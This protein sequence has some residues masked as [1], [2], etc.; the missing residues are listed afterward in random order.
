MGMIKRWSAK[1]TP[2]KV[3]KY[4]T[5]LEKTN[6]NL[7]SGYNCDWRDFANECRATN[8]LYGKAL[9][10]DERKYYHVVQSFSPYDNVTPEKAHEIALKFAEKHFKGFQ[11]L[12]ATHTDREHIHTHFIINAVS[13]ETGKKYHAD[14]KSLWS[15]RK[16]SNGYCQDYGFENSIQPLDRRAK[17]KVKSGELR[18]ILAGRESWKAEL[19]AQIET[20]KSS[21]QTAAEFK[22]MMKNEYGVEVIESTRTRRDK[23]TNI[24]QYKMPWRELPCGENRLGLDFGKESIERG[25]AERS[26]EKA[27]R[28]SSENARTAERNDSR[29]D[30]YEYRDRSVEITNIAIEKT[31]RNIAIQRGRIDELN[32]ERTLVAERTRREQEASRDAKERAERRAREE[33]ARKEEEREL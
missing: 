11:V 10:D 14:N 8:Q 2:H 12:I 29:N 6:D 26:D 9:A 19:K 31:E 3:A 1:A 28:T 15:M 22:Q 33:R 13:L 23:I 16:T 4:V 30:N 27:R 21:C 17:D 32:R 24:Y 18:T 7:I 25:F 20:A 5:D